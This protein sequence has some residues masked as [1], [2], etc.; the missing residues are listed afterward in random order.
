MA[1][2]SEEQFKA[3]REEKKAIIMNVALELFSGNGYNSTSISDIAKA[4]KISKGLMYNYFES[5]E[6]LLFNIFKIGIDQAHEVFDLNK[7]G[8]L[9]TDEMRHFITEIFALIKKNS[10]FWRLYFSLFTQKSVYELL[11]KQL[12]EFAVSMNVILIEYLR[13][14]GSEKPEVETIVFNAMLDGISF[15]YITE[16][17]MFPLEEVKEYLIKHYC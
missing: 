17:D 11:R 15:Q 4:A 3:I 5:K 10:D 9:T 12:S 1:P 13:K 16:P 8:E 7:D 6:D 14:R 2:K